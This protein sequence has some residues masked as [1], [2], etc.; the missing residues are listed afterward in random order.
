MAAVHPW[1]YPSGP[2]S[3]VHIDFATPKM[4]INYLVVVDAYSKYPEVVKMSS[5]TTSATISQLRSIFSRHGYPQTLV[6]DNGPQ[7]KSAEFGRFLEE[8]GVVHKT[9]APYKPSTNGQAER[10]VQVLKNAIKIASL[11]GK[12]EDDVIQD[13]LL[14]YRVTPHCTTGECPSQLLMKRRLRTKLDLV[15][16]SVQKRVDKVQ[17]KMMCDRNVR[18]FIPGE[19]VLIRNYGKYGDKWIPDV[20]TEKLGERHYNVHG[21]KKH[22]D[23]I[24]PVPSSSQQGNCSGVEITDDSQEDSQPEETSSVSETTHATEQPLRRSTRIS[25]PPVK[26]DL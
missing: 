15:F 6:S 16:P 22:V 10:V 25:K 21:G 3:R 24:I 18:S 13:Y 1:T 11:Q 7:F 26:L 4:G 17:D 2:W 14:A 12:N 23:Q 19:N 5:T 8:Y 9:T 20:I